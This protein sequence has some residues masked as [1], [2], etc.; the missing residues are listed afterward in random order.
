MPFIKSI[1][2][3][4]GEYVDLSSSIEVVR[5]EV[6]GVGKTRRVEK[7]AAFWRT[8]WVFGWSLGKPFQGRNEGD[9][10]ICST[11]LKKGELRR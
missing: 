3:R 1:K 2:I 10:G 5:R 4:R 9:L 11:V 8:F 6:C 7:M